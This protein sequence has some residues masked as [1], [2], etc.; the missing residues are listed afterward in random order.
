MN[1]I[2]LITKYSTKAWDQVYK[3]ESRSALLDAPSAQVQ[4]TGAKT[5]KIAKFSATG[6]GNYYRNNDGDPRNTT[7]DGAHFGYAGGNVGLT[8]EEFTLKQDRSAMY[9]IEKFDD[10]ETD[11]LTLGAA[12]TEI[13]RTIIV[14]EVDAYCFAEVAK[15]AE[16][17]GGENYKTGSIEDKPLAALN[18][19]L[20]YF[21]EHEV[22]AEK[23][24]IFVSPR[25]MTALRND[26]GGELNR[27]L[28]QSDFK[29]DVSY[30]MV[31]YEGRQLVVVPPA[32][33]RTLINMTNSG[34]TW[35]ENS[36]DI[37]FMVVAKDA[38][39]HIVKYNKV[40]VIGGDMNL[41][42]AHFDGFSIFAR[43]YHDVFVPD[44]KRYALYVHVDGLDKKSATNTLTIART[45]NLV[46]SITHKPA[47]LKARYYVYTGNEK[48]GAEIDVSGLTEVK[49]GS[50]V[51]NGTKVIAVSGK[52]IFAETTTA[53]E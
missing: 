11:G 36:K 14:P 19:A 28:L 2:E 29:K 38:V 24:I 34:Y 41:A 13:N 27:Y 44:N 7:A 17:L 40:K 21:D 42:G 18:E 33:F 52:T 47:E 6:L 15:Y 48:V 16:S 30:T 12:T 43:V 50:T 1:S 45:G 8:W 20:V 4:F 22:P 31:S 35:S 39:M 53:G 10:E 23:Q 25:Y 37:D 5:V 51:A 49:V 46:T 9:Q 26:N 3:A 32:R